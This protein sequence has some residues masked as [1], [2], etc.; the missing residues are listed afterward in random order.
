MP[1]NPSAKSGQL[2]PGKPARKPYVA[3]LLEDYGTVRELTRTGAT[4][5]AYYSDFAT[6]YT[7]TIS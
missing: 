7:S 4:Y 6:Y 2:S 5:Y 1:Q 3:P